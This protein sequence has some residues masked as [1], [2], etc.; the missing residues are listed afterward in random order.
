MFFKSISI[1]LI[2]LSNISIIFGDHIFWCNVILDNKETCTLS[3]I[4]LTKNSVDIQINAEQKEEIQN[5]YVVNS[6]IPVMTNHIC[7]AFPHLLQLS[8][9]GQNILEIQKDALDSCTEMTGLSLYGNNIQN[10]PVELFGHTTKLESI[11]LGRNQ[12]TSLDENLL[13]DLPMLHALDLQYNKLESFT[14]A[15]LR[16]NVNLAYLSLRGNQLSE[17]DAGKILEYI[18]DVDSIF[19]DE[20]TFTCKIKGNLKRLLGEKGKLEECPQ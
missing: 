2:L 14:P 13:I 11:I 9:S 17:L 1:T 19:L 15:I 7:V 20:N 8:L 4:K 12:I 5:V 3:G 10:I 18:P 16:N 6:T